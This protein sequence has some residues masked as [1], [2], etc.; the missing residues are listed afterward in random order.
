MNKIYNNI[1]ETI[2]N[3]PIVKLNQIP[4]VDSIHNFFVKLEYFNPGGSVKD[5]IALSLIDGAE[6]RGEL[7]PGGTIVEATSGNTGLGLAFI[8]ATRGYKCIFVMP[9]KISQEKRAILAAYGAKVLITPTAVEPTDSRY[10]VNVAKKI[11]DNT[12]NCFY[13]NQYHNADNRDQHY[14]VTGPEIWSQMN[15]KLDVF[16]A[17]AG[18]GGSISGIGK[19]LKEKNQNIKILCADPYGSILSDLFYH[20]KVITPA[21]SY[22][23]EGVG[24]DFLPENVQLQFMDDFEKVTDREAFRMTRELIQKEALC[25]GPSSAMA[26]VAAINYSKKFKEPKNFLVLMADNGKAYL[27]KAFNDQWMLENGFITKEELGSVFNQVTDY[28]N[29]YKELGL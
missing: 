23:V 24:E 29:Y 8:A 9:D 1:S 17:G 15:G 27:S 20:H 7:K 4:G 16:V 11:A 19:Y 13:A 26:L 22:K 12:K 14:R 21:H 2:G 3:T 28:Q 25:V 10:Y 6:R 5:R 18:T